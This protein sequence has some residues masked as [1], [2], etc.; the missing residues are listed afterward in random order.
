M[1]SPPASRLATALAAVV[2]VASSS[3]RRLAP[4]NSKD[5]AMDEFI[6]RVLDRPIDN[7]RAYS[8]SLRHP[9]AAIA[10]WI[11]FYNFFRSHSNVK[12]KSGG[13]RQNH[14]WSLVR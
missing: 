14:G 6:L 5:D 4:L 12:D 1:P 9:Y 10:L 13:G 2:V 3:R 7:E 8:N 11:C